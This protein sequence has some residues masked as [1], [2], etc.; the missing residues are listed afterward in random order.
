MSRIAGWLFFLFFIIGVSAQINAQSV[1]LAW[2]PCS[3]PTV[4]GYILYWGTGSGDY[5]NS[6]DAG[7]LAAIT[8][9]NLTAGTTYYFAVTACNAAG[10]QSPYSTEVVYSVPDGTAPS[11]TA[12]TFSNLVQTYNG[13]PESVTVTT[14]PANQPVLVTYNGSTDAPVN[15]GAYTVVAMAQSPASGSATN[16]LVISP[17]SA[18]VT[19]SGLAATYN[20]SAQTATVTTSPAGLAT[21]TTYNGSA[22]APVNAGCFAVQSTI[23]DSNYTGSATGTLVISPATA[24]LAGT[25]STLAIPVLNGSFESPEG[26]KGTVG[27]IPEG[28]L[29]SNEDPCGVYNPAVGVYASVVNDILPPPA[30]GSQLLWI[31]AGNYVAQFLTNTLEANQTYTL[32]GAIGNRGDG[33]GLAESDQDYVDLVAGS[34]ILAENVNLPH[35]A[36][37]TFLSWSIS[38]TAP[39]TGFPSGPLQIRLGQNGVGEVDFDSIA[40]TMTAP[41]GTTPAAPSTTTVV[42]SQNPA[43]DGSG[44]TFTATVSGNGGTPTGSVTFFDGTN[45]LGAGTLNSLALAAFSATGLSAAGSPHSITA[46]YGGDSAF[47]GSTSSALLQIITNITLANTGN[48]APGGSTTITLDCANFEIPAG[49]QGTVEGQPAGW[50]AANQDPYGVYNPAVGVYLCETND[51]LPPPVGGSQLLY[52]EAG[53]YV[54]QFLTNTL[55]A[56]QTYTLSGAIGNRGD[57][58]GM[59]ASD[60]AYVDLVAGNM[61]IAQ[62]SDLPHPAPGTFL[63]WTISYTA[64]AAGFPSGPLQIR[65]GQNGVGEVD[66]GN[67]TLTMTDPACTP[68]AMAIIADATAS[69]TNAT[70]ITADAPASTTDASAGTDS[71]ISNPF[72]SVAGTYHGLFCVPDNV[73]E[74]S[75]GAVTLTVTSTGA[76]SAKL[77]MEHGSYPFSGQFSG[78]GAAFQSIPRAGLSSLTAQL[79]LS[80][81]N[82]P[83][84]GTVSDG[85]WTA[86]LLA[87]P[88]VYSSTNTAPQA[89]KY[90][91]QIPGSNAASAQTGG[92][93]SGVVTVSDSGN[94][95]FSG[96]LGDGTAVTS[97]STVT[98]Q[99]Q[100]PFYLPLSGGNGSILGWLSFTNLT[101]AP[102]IGTNASG[103]APPFPAQ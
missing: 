47:G 29:P 43:P 61:I 35:P 91:W 76:F 70:L 19:L 33:Y 74:E 98:G 103:S 3:D 18:T 51:I 97:A 52:I 95:T 56:N 11:G 36:P 96:T 88:A 42:S 1:T 17:A 89:G 24:I 16:T 58:Y 82:G 75:S 38:Y 78:T 55:E 10:L 9:S 8:V 77:R 60:Q 93:G 14:S 20:G 15:A 84:T 54:A 34:T 62:N 4:T 63:A 22:A 101:S 7:P 5:T 31:E 28:W 81:T 39:A 48:P 32:S 66:F 72:A 13:A 30:D 64:P 85:T 87:E 2:N 41:G 102:A 68:D 71:S 21:T 94:A 44:V 6:E 53:N 86:D 26:G 90:A 37:G 92:N 67:I 73:A 27:G 57:G 83:L 100:W 23:N 50:L 40:L 69:T 49:A 12:F 99:G 65:L 80:L 46:V 59:V 45:N 79:Q 25:N